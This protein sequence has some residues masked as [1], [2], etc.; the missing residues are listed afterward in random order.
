M[1]GR[2]GIVGAPVGEI[3]A[4]G[5]G[6]ARIHRE[7]RRLAAPGQLDLVLGGEIVAGRIVEIEGGHGAGELRRVRQSAQLVGSSDAGERNR[8]VHQPLQRGTGEVRGGCRR[9]RLAREDAQGQVLLAGV[10]DRVHPPQP[11]LGGEGPVLHEEG[12][13]G[14]GAP[15]LRPLQDIGE[16]IEHALDLGAADGHLVDPDGGQSDAD[17]HRLAV[18]AAGADTFVHLEVIADAAHPRERIGPVADERGALDRPGDLAVLDQVGLARR[19]DELAARDVDLPA[20]EVDGVEASR[21]RAEDLRRSS[22]P[23]SMKVLVMRGMG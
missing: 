15:L 9:R 2:V 17:G 11:D 3:A 7:G 8:L 16:E 22:C 23:A 21:H 14:G 20:P 6:D 4:L 13:G 12:I 10:L 5:I 19:E 1:A 18:L